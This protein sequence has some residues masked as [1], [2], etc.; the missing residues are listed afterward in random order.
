MHSRQRSS[1]QVQQASRRDKRR[2]EAFHRGYLRSRVCIPPSI[3]QRNDLGVKGPAISRRRCT[4]VA[5]QRIGVQLGRVKPCFCA[6]SPAS[7]ELAL[8]IPWWPKNALPIQV[9]N[10]S[11]PIPPWHIATRSISH[12]GHPRHAFD[13]ISGQPT[14]TWA[15]PRH[16]APAA[17]CTALFASCRICRI[18]WSR[19]AR[20]AGRDRRQHHSCAESKRIALR[21]D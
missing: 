19:Q 12:W 17:N 1:R 13:A 11:S 4:A 5:F 6:T 14:F 7:F 3:G 15:W 21:P 16:H 8:K 20:I 9:A 18:D 2:S 10:G